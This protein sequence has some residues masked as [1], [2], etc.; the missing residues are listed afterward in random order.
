[1]AVIVVAVV[2]VDGFDDQVLRQSLRLVYQCAD[3]LLEPELDQLL[4]PLVSHNGAERYDGIDE[5][6]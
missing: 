5:V 3:V 1:M 4:W 6:D 2:S